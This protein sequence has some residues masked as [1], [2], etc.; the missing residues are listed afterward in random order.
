MQSC[1]TM[2]KYE[3]NHDFFTK[4]YNLKRNCSYCW[5]LIQNNM[6]NGW[7]E[8]IMAYNLI[9]RLLFLNRQIHFLLLAALNI[10]II[11]VTFTTLIPPYDHARQGENSTH[12]R[13]RPPAFVAAISRVVPRIV[14]HHRVSLPTCLRCV[15]CL[16]FISSTVKQWFLHTMYHVN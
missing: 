12:L 11:I 2:I 9:R 7:I 13:W 8:G 10:K 14:A 16:K 6:Q 3:I 5:V 1:Q 15:D 4:V